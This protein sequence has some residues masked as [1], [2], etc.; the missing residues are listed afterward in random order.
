MSKAFI[1]VLKAYHA[2]M[3]RE[4]YLN[5]AWAGRPPVELDPELKAELEEEFPEDD[6]A[7]QGEQ[8][9]LNDKPPDA[10]QTE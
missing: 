6:A 4:S 2:P 3:T 1:N 10:H 5:T 8:R 9:C 7:I